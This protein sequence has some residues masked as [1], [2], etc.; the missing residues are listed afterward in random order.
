MVDPIDF[1]GV[2]MGDKGSHS[3]S[4]VRRKNNSVFANNTDCSGQFKTP[5]FGNLRFSKL[6]VC[7]VLFMLDRRF[8]RN[9]KIC[10]EFVSDS[11]KTFSAM[12]N[13]SDPGGKCLSIIHGLADSPRRSCHLEVSMIGRR[14]SCPSGIVS[15]RLGYLRG[16][17]VR[18][19]NPMS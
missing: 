15:C 10:D 6:V 9:G 1:L 19:V 8:P 12:I 14:W 18:L 5:I 3:R 4:G 16:P 2:F 7:P 11:L 17:R 13:S